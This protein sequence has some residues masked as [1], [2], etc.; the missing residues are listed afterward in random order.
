MTAIKG[1]LFDK[2]GTLFDFQA[3]WSAWARTMLTDL[4]A[5]DAA[6][7]A[8][9]GTRIGYDFGAGVFDPSSLVIAG[10]PDDIVGALLP[11]L[12]GIGPA[13]LVARLNA[14]AA[15]A[16]QAEAVPLGPLLGVLRSMG[17]ALGV[18]TNDAEAPARA[19]L[20]AAGQEDAFDFI[21][22]YDSGFGGKP[23]P[24]MCLGFSQAVGL[25]PA[26]VLM[27]GDST[28]DLEAGR[29]AGMRTIAVLT[30]MAGAEVL[31]PLA[32]AVLPDIG[33]LPGWI[34]AQRT[35]AGTD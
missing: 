6:R 10:T 22:G 7:A 19:H 21:A 35:G 18:A 29:A 31:A 26:H 16:P 28:H 8:S 9:L 34:A 15:R 17:M 25:D 11:A 13:E 4:A 33:H 32:T 1:I 5:G 14:A 23:G 2:D 20:A 3:T 30:G 24:G 27:V 12:P